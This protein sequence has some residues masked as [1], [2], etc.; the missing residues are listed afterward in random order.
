[1]RRHNLLLVPS[2]ALVGVAAPSL[3]SAGSTPPPSA[4]PAPAGSAPADS[5]VPVDP[6]LQ[7]RV[8]AAFAAIDP[9]ATEAG[10][11][12]D[13]DPIAVNDPIGLAAAEEPGPGDLCLS[14]FEALVA[15]DGTFAGQLAGGTSERYYFTDD[16][17]LP[18]DDS[19]YELDYVEGSVAI[20]DPAATAGFEPL[21]ALLSGDEVEQCLSDAFGPAAEEEGIENFEFSTSTDT[22]DVGDHAALFSYE[23]SGDVDGEAQATSTIAAI[24][25]AG[26]AVVVVT[27]DSASTG[28]SPEVVT[29]SLTAMVEAVAPAPA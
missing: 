26:D 11:V 22:L 2:L 25:V 12:G 13:D 27:Y 20:L 8:D 4:P 21:V 7:A 15:E 18:T 17:P 10:F 6:A 28:L 23:L 29:E 14:G 3:V 1:M 24:A 16:G 19:M 9:I 5:G